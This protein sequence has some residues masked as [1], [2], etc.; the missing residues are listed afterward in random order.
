MSC[1][2]LLW[3][4]SKNS[5][6][7]RMRTQKPTLMMMSIASSTPIDIHGDFEQKSG[8]GGSDP[9]PLATAS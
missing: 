6:S 4:M 7:T 1:M 8:G 2:K 5:S 3:M 9:S